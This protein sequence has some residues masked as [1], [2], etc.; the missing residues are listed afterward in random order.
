MHTEKKNLIDSFRPYPLRFAELP[1]DVIERDYNQPRKVFGIRG[2]S[3]LSRLLKSIAHYGIEDPIKVCEVESGRYLIMD[4]HRRFACAKELELE[5]VPCRIYPKMDAGEFEARRYEMQNN[6]R[7]WRP[8]EK[9]NAIHRIKT[10]YSDASE[11]E[12]ADLIGIRQ[13]TLFHFTALRDMRIE[14]LE[15]MS[16]H[17]LKEHQRISFM[18]LLPR[19]RKIKPYEVDDIVKILF[20][21]I[22]DNLL[23]RRKDFVA[24]SKIFSMASLNE[25]ELLYFLTEPQ[26]SVIELCEMTQLSG[27]ST[28]IR[29]LTKELSVKKNLNIKLTTKEQNLF[30]DLYKLME[31]FI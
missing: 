13:T 30:E 24:L 2:G 29:N 20:K 26:V 27:V 1:L 25:E 14:Y 6:R 12:V 31:N 10:E 21:K 4:G 9:A 8:I 22:N 18:Q 16:E 15:L 7:D 17:D 23:Y 19:L 5:K 3:D 11:K 28:Q